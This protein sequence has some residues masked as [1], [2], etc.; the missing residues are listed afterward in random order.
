VFG[1]PESFDPHKD[2][3]VRV[4]AHRLR[5][6]LNDYFATQGR[7]DP[8]QIVLP[9]R[10]YRL[11]IRPRPAQGSPPAKEEITLAVRMPWPDR[12]PT[13]RTDRWHR[14]LMIDTLDALARLEGLRVMVRAHTLMAIY[15]ERPASEAI[16]ALEKARTLSHGVP[17][18]LGALGHAYGVF[19]MAGPAR[20]VLDQLLQAAHTRYVPAVEIA[21]VCFGLGQPEQGFD[22]LARALD[23]RCASL[24][25]L[26]VDPRAK[27]WRRNPRARKFLQTMSPAEPRPLEPH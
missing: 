19:G 3:V 24:A 11:L 9:G 23:E 1:K 22:W 14:G 8:V 10:S 25:W 20:A 7:D 12:D 26:P 18:V 4:E 16:A 5:A 17:F 21:W 6:R 27:P 2:T 13:R 15:G